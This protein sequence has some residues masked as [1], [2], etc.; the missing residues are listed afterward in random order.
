MKSKIVK[1]VLVTSIVAAISA[2]SVMARQAGPVMIDDNQATKIHFGSDLMATVKAES[3]DGDVRSLPLAKQWYPGDAIKSVPRRLYPNELNTSLRAPLNPVQGGEDPLLARQAE[4]EGQFSHAVAAGNVNIEGLGFTGVNPSDPT[5]AVGKNH[6]IQSING[7]NGAVFNIYDKSGNKVSGPT[8]MSTL[9]VNRCKTSL[10]D[11][12]VFYDEAAE[13]YVMTEFS[14]QTGRSLCVY[15]SKTDNPVSGGWH[16]YE[17]QAPEF[18][19]YPKFG[20]YGDSYYVG[21]N[22]SAGPGIYALERS[23]MLTGATARMVRKTVPKLPNLGFQML[24]PVDVDTATGPAGS[25]PGIFIR[26]RDDEMINPGS[27]NS[28]KDYI[29]LWTYAPNYDNASSSQLV[30]PINIEV[31]EFDSKFCVGSQGFGCLTQK[32]S[33]TTLD[34]VKEVLMYRAQYRKFQ[35]S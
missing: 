2:P 25:E 10:G 16:S 32:G 20:R 4:V 18:P 14:N 19:D 15:V 7:S 8:A 5:G 13:R 17:F 9:G 26:Q 21:T 6:Y 31:S 30:G 12:I 24:V 29:E 3:F 33:S 34:P 23:K 35:R 11:P 1:S 28:S 22:E 27:N